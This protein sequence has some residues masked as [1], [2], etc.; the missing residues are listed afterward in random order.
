[1]AEFRVDT[2]AISKMMD[3]DFIAIGKSGISSK[4]QEL[5]GI[6]KEMS[7][8]KRNQ[9]IVDSLYFEDSHIAIYGQTA[10]VTFISVTKGKVKEV[11][12]AKRRTRMYDVWIK[13]N[14]L[15]KAVSSQVTPLNR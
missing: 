12:F 5:N 15:W 14:G 6:F 11:P 8:R 13:K 10:V 9:H 1:M 4:Q 3:K 2:A 7:Q